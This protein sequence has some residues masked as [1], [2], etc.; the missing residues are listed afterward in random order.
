LEQQTL[1]SPCGTAGAVAP[2]PDRIEACGACAPALRRS[3]LASLLAATLAGGAAHAWEP[4]RVEPRVD[5]LAELVSGCAERR[6]PLDAWFAYQATADGKAVTAAAPAAASAASPCTEAAVLARL[7]TRPPGVW[8]IA[9]GDPDGGGELF[10]TVNL[11]VSALLAS[12]DGGRTWRYRHVFLRGY[13]RDR[14]TQLRGLDARHGRLA[15][16]TEDGV[17]LSDDGGRSFTAALAGRPFTDVA[18]S[19]AS[20]QWVVAAGDGTSFSSLDGGATWTPLRFTEFT[21]ALATRNRYLTDH[22]T[23][24]EFDATDPAT[25]YVGTGSHL[26]RFVINGHDLASGRWQVL[27][28]DAQGRVLDDSTVYNVE[29]GSRFMISTCNG[30]YELRRRSSDLA[31]DHADVSWRKFRDQAW[32]ARNVGGPRGNLRSYFV[33]EDPLDR[34]RI[35][36]ADFAALYEGRRGP[37]GLRWRRVDELPYAASP[38]GGY[39]EYTA[40]AW[41]GS[42]DAVVGSR[43]RGIFVQPRSR[44]SGLATASAGAGATAGSGAPVAAAGRGTSR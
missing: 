41:T 35:L 33:A 44:P 9:A 4:A 39:P 2:S 3:L 42:G 13:N 23:S 31:R 18:I 6:A 28:G 24:I 12:A 14:A 25:A 7:G 19:P 30:V 22:I 11:P 10:A 1:H 21:R 29:I 8:A 37:S 26:Y 38:A 34:D 43:Y 15:V 16:A 20:R 36:V 17:L 5:N 40:I 32:S 27:E